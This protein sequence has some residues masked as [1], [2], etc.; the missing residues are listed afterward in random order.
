MLSMHDLQIYSSC[1]ISHSWLTLQHS[2]SCKTW[3]KTHQSSM[4]CVKEQLRN[5]HSVHKI[6]IMAFWQLQMSSNKVINRSKIATCCKEKIQRNPAL[7]AQLL[8]VLTVLKVR[9]R[10]QRR[11]AI[12]QVLCCH[13]RFFLWV[14]F[15]CIL[16]TV[17]CFHTYSNGSMPQACFSANTRVK[18]LTHTCTHKLLHAHLVRINQRGLALVTSLFPVFF[19]CDWDG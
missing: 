8:G 10:W 9:G 3:R 12:F 15:I 18:V 14:P 19:L 2:L 5:S 7:S 11:N 6:S 4:W 1:W 17:D 13:I 16:P